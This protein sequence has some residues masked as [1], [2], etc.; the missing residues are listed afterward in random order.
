MGKINRLCEDNGSYERLTRFKRNTI[1]GTSREME[2]A[3]FIGDD[4]RLFPAAVLRPAI[5]TAQLYQQ[6][7][8]CIL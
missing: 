6:V 3:P 5:A 4:D 1:L 7:F 8:A 2:N